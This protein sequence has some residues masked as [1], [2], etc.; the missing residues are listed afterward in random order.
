MSRICNH[1]VGGHVNKR[2]NA[3]NR[4]GEG[5]GEVG[6]GRVIVENEKGMDGIEMLWRLRLWR[7]SPRPAEEQGWPGAKPAYMGR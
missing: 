2:I 5:G 3:E 4:E 1:L 7:V 6:E